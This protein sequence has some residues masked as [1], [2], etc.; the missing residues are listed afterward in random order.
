MPLGQDGALRLTTARYYTPS[1]RSIQAKG[2]DPDVEILEDVPEDL[3]GKDDTKG[4]ASLKGHLKNGED[5][6]T[7]SQ[8]YVPADPKND[9]QL[10]AAVDLLHGVKHA[11]VVPAKADANASGSTPAAAPPDAPKDAPAAL[12]APSK[13]DAA[14]PN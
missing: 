1:G 7:G 10:I 13:P 11:A 4:E 3:K 9:K 8:A 12:P 6:K 2:I 5:E 14:Q